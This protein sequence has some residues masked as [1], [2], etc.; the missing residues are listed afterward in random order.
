[1]RSERPS[2]EAG[3]VVTAASARSARRPRA[4][5]RATP[6][7]KLRA[8]LRPLVVS[9]KVTP[10]V[11]SVAGLPGAWSQCRSSSTGISGRLSGFETSGASGKSTGT[12]SGNPAAA[13]SFTRLYSSPSPTIIAFTV[14]SCAIAPARSTSSISSA[15]NSTGWRR[16]TTGSSASNARFSAGRS[17]PEG[18]LR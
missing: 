10:A 3:T 18:D 15:T 12:T 5:A 2:I 14:A 9:A 6:A 4:I 8:S 13:I 7:R 11:W 17:R 1:M 16:S